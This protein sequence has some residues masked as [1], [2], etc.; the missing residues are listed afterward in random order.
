MKEIEAELETR[1]SK[2]KYG[3]DLTGILEEG[4]ALQ[5]HKYV[6]LVDPQTFLTHH[7]AG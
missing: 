4:I 1:F 2:T 7:V 3:R 5:E 6:C